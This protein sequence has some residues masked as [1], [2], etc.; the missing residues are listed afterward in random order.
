MSDE[1]ATRLINSVVCMGVIQTL[2]KNAQKDQKEEL[3]VC[4]KSNRVETCTI[5]RQRMLDQV[6]ALNNIR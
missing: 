6:A 5:I 4:M 2:Y 1:T 3:E